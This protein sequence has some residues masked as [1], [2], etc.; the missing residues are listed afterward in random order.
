MEDLLCDSISDS[1]SN[2]AIWVLHYL[3]WLL[4]NMGI[5]LSSFTQIYWDAKMNSFNSNHTGDHWWSPGSNPEAKVL[6]FC[7]IVSDCKKRD[8]KYLAQCL[9]YCKLPAQQP[10]TRGGL[11]SSRWGGF[12][13]TPRRASKPHRCPSDSSPTFHLAHCFHLYFIFFMSSFLI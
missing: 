10:Q 3:I 6:P 5:T 9:A 12:L 1:Y 2:N 8:P 13:G 7:Y 4:P 11:G